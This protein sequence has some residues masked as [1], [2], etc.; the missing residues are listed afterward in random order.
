MVGP[1]RSRPVAYVALADQA[2]RAVIADTLELLGWAV[3]QP[4]TS[5]HLVEAMSGLILGVE[6]WERVALVVVDER[7]PGCRGSSIASG[8]RQLGIDVPVA[9][10]GRTADPDVAA[11]DLPHR[12]L[13]VV[14]P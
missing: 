4:S 10:V 3:I 11:L 5:F 6:P 9:L 7:S 8:L 14:A 1:R 2:L 12:G 13:H